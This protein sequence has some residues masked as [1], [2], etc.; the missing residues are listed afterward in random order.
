MKIALR[1]V[2]LSL[3]LGMSA[4]AAGAQV[5]PPFKLSSSEIDRMVAEAARGAALGS[6]PTGERGPKVVVLRRTKSGEAE[7]HEGLHDLFIVRSGRATVTIGG[8]IAGNRQ[9]SPGEWRG[10][11]ISGGTKFEVEPGDVLWIPAGLPH[12][13]LLSDNGEVSYLAL[14]SPK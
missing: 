9:T 3:L 1:K 6:V 8:T 11:T 5:A 14:K 12:Q 13:V 4:T 2:C 10:G 7:V